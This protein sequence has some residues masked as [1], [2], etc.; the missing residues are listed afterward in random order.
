MIPVS[1]KL[2]NF[3]SYGEDVEPLDFTRF[4]V[5]CL[6]GPNGHGKSALLDAMTWALWGEA[7]KSANE[8]KPDDGLLRLGTTQMR[9]EFEFELDGDRYRVLREYRRRRS[10]GTARL[11]FQVFEP[12]AQTYRPLTGPTLSATQERINQRLGMDYTTFV[13]SAFLLQGRADEFT[14]KNARE[15]KAILADILG[16]ARYD[17]LAERARARQREAEQTV[18]LCQERLG[19]YE[20]ELQHREEYEERL[21]ELE[22]Q[23]RNWAETLERE[24]QRLAELR[25]HRQELVAQRQQLP[26]LERTLL[27]LDRDL[28][29]LQA[30]AAAERQQVETYQ[31][32]LDQRE[33]IEAAQRR[34][35]ELQAQ[36]QAFTR[37]LQTLR[38]LEVERNRLERAIGEA[39]YHLESQ[40]REGEARREQ[41][42]E[43]LRE[44]EEVLSRAAEIE[45]GWS[46]LQKARAI[47][48]QWERRREEVEE[49]E[50]QERDLQR[51][52]EAAQNE[53]KVQLQALTHRLR[54]NQQRA[55]DTPARQQRLAQAQEALKRA[56]EAAVERDRIR[57]QANELTTRI[58]VLKDRRELLQREMEQTE[59]KRVLLQQGEEAQCPLC[60]SDLGEQGIRRIY[61][62]FDADI[63]ACQEQIGRIVQEGKALAHQRQELFAQFQEREQRVAQIPALQRQ[64]AAA[65]TAWQEGLAAQ[66][67]AE[68]IQSQ[69]AELQRQLET[70]AYAP[71]KVEA[72]R[73]VQSQRARLSYDPAKREV[74]RRAV[75]D[76]QA[77]ELEQAR[78]NQARAQR[79]QLMPALRKLEQSLAQIEAQL[80]QGQYAVEEQ[81]QL[82]T[83]E[84]QIAAL[85]Y[86][87]DAHQSLRAEWEALRDAPRQQERL[88]EAERR[89]PALLETHQQTEAAIAAREQRRTEAQAERDRLLAAVVGLEELERELGELEDRHRESQRAREALLPE[90]GHLQ[91]RVQRCQ[92]L[93]AELGDARDRLAQAQHDR[94]IYARLVTAFGKDGIQA[95]I[96]ENATPEIEA[97]ANQILRRLTNNRTQIAIE[98]LRD[99]K[100]GGTKETLDI[101]ISDELGTRDYETFSGGERFRVDF[102]LRLALS[103]LLARRAGT[104]LRILVIDEGFGTQD[105]EGLEHLVEAIREISG[106]FDK[107]LVVTHLETLK[108]AFPTRIEVFKEPETGSRFTMVG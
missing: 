15:R 14:R 90:H 81:A 46:E 13:N 34:F 56:E 91:A 96:I 60:N 102:A 50:R 87:A 83:V 1:L 35:E 8:R 55:A 16:L 49:L 25:E 72:W 36:E 41:G 9:V 5:A 101:H 68:A 54:E 106:E 66:R 39:R 2:Q 27:Q 42:R 3:L 98:P 23:L 85:A 103:K 64:V 108:N 86:D 28:S 107:I 26:E 31:R 71:E 44:V 24:E 95:L 104:R 89:M 43:R 7:R 17:R 99:L 58:N 92:Q 18:I 69:I 97:E 22:Q 12:Q 67:E 29:E 57:Q 52:I 79:E 94:D 53:L 75:R 84:E 47:E 80:Q 11:E 76:L 62:K 77:W 70:Q 20:E 100:T 93:A 51:E 78:L 63:A 88:A 32:V 59:E 21:A 73:Q 30:R 40:R 4:H 10:G 105:T 65:E 38:Q 33:Q 37:K 61:A 74:V 45:R 6:S 48:E 82:R 19:R